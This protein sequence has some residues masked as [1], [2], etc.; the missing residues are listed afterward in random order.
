MKETDSRAILLRCII[1]SIIGITMFVIIYGVSPLN[2]KNDTWILSGYS[3]WDIQ[4]DYAGWINYRNSS[5]NFPIAQAD[6][7]GF[8]AEKGV[9]IA[10]TDSCPL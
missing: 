1:G 5:W 9:N 6:K 7:M 2:V 10:F 4:Q 3:E 8:P